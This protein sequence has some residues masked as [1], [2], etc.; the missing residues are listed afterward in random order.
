MTRVKLAIPEAWKKPFPPPTTFE[1]ALL[2]LGLGAYLL[3]AS[4]ASIATNLEPFVILFLLLAISLIGVRVLFLVRKDCLAIL[5]RGKARWLA[6]GLGG[7]FILLGQTTNLGLILRLRFSESAI[8]EYIDSLPNQNHYSSRH[9][10]PCGFF[11]ILETDSD[12]GT[13]WLTTVHGQPFL[14][15]IVYCPIGT[16]QQ[17]G[18]SE[19]QHLYGPWW[20]WLQDI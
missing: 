16:P 6:L 19:Y 4:D 15:G 1:I 13:V 10:L 8:C 9:S 2:Y 18:E 12:S 3:A 7:M 11:T 17:I 14:A 5:R 20:R